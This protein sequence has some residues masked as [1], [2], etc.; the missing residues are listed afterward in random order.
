[1]TREEFK[2]WILSEFENVSSEV[3]E[4]QKV[5][6][7]R[8]DLETLGEASKNQLEN[9][10]ENLGDFERETLEKRIAK[11]DEADDATPIFA[12]LHESEALV[13]FEVKTGAAL[14]RILREKES[15]VPSKILDERE[16]SRVIGFG[17]IS[18]DET[19]DLVRLSF[20]IATE[21]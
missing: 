11:A 1:M 6:I 8:V 9:G 21:A 12:V 18:R 7:F 19:Q 20:R 15:V 3:L 2:N 5:E 10:G 14:A 13:S 17:Q 16:W 4:A